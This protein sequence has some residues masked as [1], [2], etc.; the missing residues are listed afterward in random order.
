M[1]HQVRLCARPQRNAADHTRLIASPHCHAAMMFFRSRD[2]QARHW[3]WGGLM[4]RW[5]CAALPAFPHSCADVGCTAVRRI[6]DRARL[7]QY[8]D[9]A[10]HPTARI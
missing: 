8:G 10:V 1:C 2:R 4:W 9:G 7:P 5:R 6:P 3:W